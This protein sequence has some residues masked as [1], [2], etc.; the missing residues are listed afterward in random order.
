GRRHWRGAYV[1]PRWKRHNG[2]ALEALPGQALATGEA[3]T[4]ISYAKNAA[5]VD[6]AP[7]ARAQ[8]RQA[9]MTALATLGGP[10]LH[11][12]LAVRVITASVA[13][14]A[15]PRCRVMLAPHHGQAGGGGPGGRRLPQGVDTP[16]RPATPPH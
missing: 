8:V 13:S 12:E 9:A 6:A 11:K 7:R 14:V 16:R 4:T 5:I 10:L 2:R 3:M 15:G 1:G